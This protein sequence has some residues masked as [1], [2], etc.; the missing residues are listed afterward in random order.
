MNGLSDVR[1]SNNAV[2]P[3]MTNNHTTN[4]QTGSGKTDKE[5]ALDAP[6]QETSSSNRDSE[7]IISGIDLLDY[8]AGGLRPH[9]LYLVRGSGGTG[10][11][12]LGLQFLARGLELQE[13]GILITDQKP[14]RRLGQGRT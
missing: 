4:N 2:P 7:R 1:S 6:V 13:P 3:P 8:S 12:L 14:E 5:L 11:S 10:K 9:K